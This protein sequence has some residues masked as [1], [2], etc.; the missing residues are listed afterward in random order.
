M[1]HKLKSV[2]F[3]VSPPKTQ[4]EL[5]EIIEAFKAQGASE[6][7]IKQL[8]QKTKFHEKVKFL[9]FMGVIGENR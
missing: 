7:V 5:N 9:R 4:Q 8:E 1:N 2:K 6:V 3:P